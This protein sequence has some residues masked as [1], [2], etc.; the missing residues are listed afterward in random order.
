M[1]K[2]LLLS[3]SLS[4]ILSSILLPT[5]FSAAPAHAEQ[6]W[7]VQIVDANAV[8]GG[9]GYA[10][11]AV[12]SN[13][14]SHIGYS[15]KY[16]P[17]TGYR[18]EYAV[19]NGSDWIIKEVPNGFVTDLKLDANDNPH[20]ILDHG[21]YIRWTGTEWYTQ[22]I[23]STEGSVYASLALDSSGNPHVTYVDGEG[24]KY[25]SLTGSSWNNQ[26]VDAS[27]T[28]ISFQLSLA[29]DKNNVSYILY[30][31][32]S[33]YVDKSIG[34][35]RLVDI[36]LA[37]W[38]NSH[39]NIEPILASSNIGECWNMVLDSKGHPH[40]LATQCRYFS[41]AENGIILLSTIL[42]VSWNG[43][44]W[45][46][47]TV[48]SDVDLSNRGFLALD[49]Y[50]NPSI[51]YAE[52]DDVLKYAAWTGREWIIQAVDTIIP[53]VAWTGTEWAVQS[54]TSAP[55]TLVDGPCY[56]AVDS[57]RIPHISFRGVVYQQPHWHAASILYATVSEPVPLYS[58]LPLQLVLTA[59][60]II[61]TAVIVC[62]WRKK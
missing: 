61:A 34:G 6:G 46:T 39:W 28:E 50:D 51:V 4:L 52:S 35:A 48:I 40:F 22:T 33:S 59:V 37:V 36:K 19:L 23:P 15:G 16:D 55:L 41:S 5:F 42:Y 18:P 47:Q 43:F 12:D 56:L 13:N 9:N 62:L 17:L 7:S 11:I 1:N 10:P 21:T 8:A 20:M 44:G 31:T 53:T 57:D 14:V 32:P 60:T 29:L 27:Y 30:A 25:A 3:A 58:P 38:K 26:T 2:K 24:L 49:A 54:G 45:N